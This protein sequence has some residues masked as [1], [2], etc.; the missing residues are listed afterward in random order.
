MQLDAII[1]TASLFDFF[2]MAILADLTFFLPRSRV[3]SLIQSSLDFA[4]HYQTLNF[5]KMVGTQN[6]S[7]T[8]LQFL[9]GQATCRSAVALEGVPSGLPK[10]LKMFW[11]TTY[12]D[13]GMC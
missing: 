8:L 9:D 5:A 2:L 7:E 1:F 3:M 6:I 13:K 12:S 4:S 11:A 10:A